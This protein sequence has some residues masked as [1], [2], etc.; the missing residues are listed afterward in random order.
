MRIFFFQAVVDIVIVVEITLRE[1]LIA[2]LHILQREWR[3]VS[4]LGTSGRPFIGLWIAYGILYGIADFL[5][6][7]L[8]I[9]AGDKLSASHRTRQTGI[10]HKHAVHSGILAELKHLMV[11]KSPRRPIA[12]QVVL[13][14]A[15]HRVAE[16]LFPSHAVVKHHPFDDATS[17]PTHEFRLHVDEKLRQIGTQAVWTATK[18]VLRE[19]R[20][21]VDAHRS[22]A[23]KNQRKVSIVYGGAGGHHRTELMPFSIGV[24]IKSNRRKHPCAVLVINNRR[25]FTFI[26]SRR[27]IKPEVVLGIFL[28]GHAPV[29]GINQ[30]RLRVFRSPGDFNT[31]GIGSGFVKRHRRNRHIVT[32]RTSSRI[33]FPPGHFFAGKIP[34]PCDSVPRKVVIPDYFLGLYQIIADRFKSAGNRVF[35]KSAVTDKF[36]IQAAVAR[37]IDFFKKYTVHR[38]IYVSAPLIGVYIKTVVG[39]SG[40][41]TGHQNRQYRIKAFFHDI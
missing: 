27:K 31:H 5:I 16:S 7:R 25:H 4:G 32:Y 30:T 40:R 21:I 15:R 22:A 33:D 18:C 41:R 8:D 20:H 6:E 17:R 24:H 1:V 28:H 23:G 11:A 13:S 19:Q 36:G 14:W 10:A 37:M 34:L 35:F 26:I 29:A 2:Y 9:G 3:R 38:G 39:H 12:P